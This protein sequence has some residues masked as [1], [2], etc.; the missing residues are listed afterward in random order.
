VLPSSGRTSYAYLDGYVAI[1]EV[2]LA[3][4]AAAVG[5]A[6]ELRKAAGNA[7]RALQRFA[8]VYPVAQSRALLCQGRYSWQEGKPR[9]A[10]ASWL[11]SL[12][13][14]ERLDMPYDQGLAYLEIGKH[15]DTSDPARREHLNRARDMFERIGAAH[16]LARAEDLLDE[17]AIAVGDDRR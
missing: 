3:R 17:K 5:E 7:H 12:A 6:N 13:A 9:L 1:F 8:G 14:A 11:K 15:L 4:W 10:H 16:D 2:C